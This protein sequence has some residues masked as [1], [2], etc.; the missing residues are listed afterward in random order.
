MEIG[1]KKSGIDVVGNVP[2]GTHLCHFYQSK[3]DLIDVLVPYFRT[4]LEN[5]EFCMWVSCESFTEEEVMAAM[6]EGVSDFD[7]Y[8]ERGQMEIVSHTEWYLKEGVFNLRRVLNAW[9]DKLN[10]ALSKGYEGIRVT[11]QV[12]F[13]KGDWKNLIE[14][15]KVVNDIIGK[16]KMS[17]VC[18]YDLDKCGANEILDAVSCHRVALIKR[19]GK[20]K[21]IENAEQKKA[22]AAQK[23][24]EEQQI[25]RLEIL[26]TFHQR[27]SLKTISEEVISLIKKHLGCEV[28]ALRLKEGEDY[29]FF[30]NNGFP[31]EFI[32]SENYLLAR[33]E[34]GDYLRDSSGR[35]VLACMC[36]IVINSKANQDKPFF[37]KEGS[38]W[39]NST[40]ELLASTNETEKGAT[41]RNL[42]NQY[43]YESV[44]LIPVK[45]RNGNLGLLQINSKKRNFFSVEDIEFLEEL[46]HLIGMAVEHKQAEEACVRS[47]YRFK[48]IFDNA[49]DGILL[50]DSESMK[51]LAANKMICQM[52]G[53]EQEELK[54]MGVSDIHPKE[55]LPYIVEQF[56]RQ[57][58]R[59][60]SLTTEIPVK[61]K[62]GSIFYADISGSPVEVFENKY[63]L[64]I[65]RDITE[66]KKAEQDLQESEKKYRLLVETLNE[67]VWNIDKDGYTTFVNPRMARML[68][69]TVEGM[70]GKH[71]F[72]FMNEEGIEIC[73]QH[74]ARR[75]QGIDEQHDFEFIR[76]DGERVYTSLAATSIIDNNGNYIGAIAGVQDISRRK[77][78]ESALAESEVKYRN[79]IEKL[80]AITYTAALDKKGTILY[81]SPQIEG[82]LG[83][84]VQEC[85]A[86]PDIWYKC[87]YSAD[88]ERV[89]QEM[90]RT[91]I[92]QEPF[93]CE[94][95]M[96]AKDGRVIWFRD[97]AVVVKDY[98]GKPSCLQG[99]MYD[100]TKRKQAEEIVKKVNK[101]LL[102]FGS[103][104]EENIKKVLETA[105]LI[106]GGFCVVYNGESG[107]FYGGIEKW[108]IP[109][110]FKEEIK[111][112]KCI[113]CKVMEEV[114]RDK[115]PCVINNLDNTPFT[116]GN[117]NIVTHKLKTYMGCIVQRNNKIIGVLGIFFQ[118]NREFNSNELKAVTLLTNIL[119]IEKERREAHKKLRHEKEKVEGVLKRLNNAYKELKIM[120]NELLKHERIAVT[121]DLVAGV[122]H[123]IR[124]P[125]TIISMTVQYLQNKLH[126]NDP[127][128][129]LTEAIIRKVERLDRVTRELSSYGRTRYLNIKRKNLEKCL[130]F[131]LAL[132]KPKCKAYGIKINKKYSKLPLVEI[133]EEQID[134]VFLNIM[135]NAVWAMSKKGGL[136]T[137]V[138]D[139]EEDTKKVII[140]IHNTGPLIPQRHISHIFEPFYTL[141]KGEGTGLGLAIVQSVILRHK[142]EIK[143]ENKSSG[144]N[145]GVAFIIRLPIIYFDEKK[146]RDKNNYE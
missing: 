135:D 47:E 137:V 134:K 90:K 128:K 10:Q 12:W 103:N 84:S 19:G 129:E 24:T 72:S 107:F 17:A 99:I 85:K 118:K 71:L 7:R 36:G 68:G 93:I 110:N 86:Q 94:Y 138:T 88:R 32:K 95:R 96:V 146:E 124:N 29:P 60:P 73:K 54:R 139:F 59:M 9:V 97:E 45:S 63:L 116:K 27:E 83:I 8:V 46:G 66:R 14:Y 74:L 78:V 5:N 75:K 53:Y 61:R 141:K 121:G 34:K 123:E 100:V 117:P 20:W 98:D 31:E 77:R 38:F 115:K 50:A 52:L 145:K 44:A 105:R 80:P 21:R 120:Q 2:W 69:Y 16:H 133:D 33:D 30:V 136:L 130:N 122:A 82:F 113:Y 40:T 55:D 58:N 6:R 49:I 104:P 18:S 15:E 109:A 89:L 43:G 28:S 76:K 111:K 57:L 42:C 91:H 64:G 132:I 108:E 26:K 65:F 13:D 142:G 101:C 35:P 87:L 112:D 140:K 23:R 11:G 62:D 51:F 114:K 39:T 4:G 79:L 143:V 56:D 127:K 125:L 106:L 81:V 41:T 131:S 48:A 144:E 22:K 92:T 1:I 37:S 119:G 25:L 3:D 70:L 102:S 67:G 126:E